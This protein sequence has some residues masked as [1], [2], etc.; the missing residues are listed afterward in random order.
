MAVRISDSR[1][2]IKLGPGGT[3]IPYFRAEYYIDELGP[4]VYEVKLSENT[5]EAFI[6]E[7]EHRRMVLEAVKKIA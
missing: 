5:P 7:V 6:K 1:D 2:T 4:F 3:M